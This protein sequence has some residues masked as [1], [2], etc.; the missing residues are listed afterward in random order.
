[1][2]KGG[3]L[4]GEAMAVDVLWDGDC[5]TVFE[6]P[7][8][9]TRNT[10]GTG[11]TLASEIAANISLG[12]R[13]HDAVRGAKTYITEAIRHGLAIGKGQGPTHHFYFIDRFW[14]VRNKSF[15]VT[16]C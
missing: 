7:R 9:D 12:E 11:C 14:S 3:H 4:D 13:L 15:T 16:S 8:L 2:V 5:E 10:H 1:M 6:S